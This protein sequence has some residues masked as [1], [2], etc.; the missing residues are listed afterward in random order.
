MR[1]EQ[2]IYCIMGATGSGKSTFLHKARE[3]IGAHTVEV[4]KMLRAKY[5]P[6]YFEGSAAPTKTA[7]EAWNMCV[8]GIKAGKDKIILVD[9]QPRDVQQARNMMKTFPEAKYILFN[10]P[11]EE[12]MYRLNNRDSGAALE[13]AKA[14]LE[15]DYVTMFPVIAELLSCGK[16]IM[17]FNSGPDDP[18]LLMECL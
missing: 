8:Q 3:L 5:P 18:R 7:K 1:E 2:N 13:L 17:V 14:R 15:G 4:G 12:R 9:G 10:C 16:E 6:E 11:T